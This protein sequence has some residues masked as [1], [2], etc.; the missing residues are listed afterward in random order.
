MSSPSYL[1]IHNIHFTNESEFQNWMIGGARNVE[2]KDEVAKLLFEKIL[3]KK[4]LVRKQEETLAIAIALVF[5]RALSKQG[6]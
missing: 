4:L 6:L 1:K 5:I 3:C 2:F